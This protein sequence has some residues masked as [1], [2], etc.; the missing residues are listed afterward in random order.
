MK[1]I[2]RILLTIGGLAVAAALAIALFNLEVSAIFLLVLA[3]GGPAIILTDAA[4]GF[5][6]QPNLNRKNFLGKFFIWIYNLAWGFLVGYGLVDIIFKLI[7][8]YEESLAMP[9]IMLFVG[10]AM[11]IVYLVAIARKDPDVRKELDIAKK[12]ERIMANNHKA[13]HN[14]YYATLCGL[15]IF[16]ALVGLLPITSTTI[17]VIGIVA[18]CALSFALTVILYLR[19]DKDK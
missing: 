4:I 6:R 10:I 2:R 3:I 11:F 5:A 12:D 15:L 13:S 18:I 19:Y 8:G 1:I 17:I 9:M 7:D 16:A 14:S